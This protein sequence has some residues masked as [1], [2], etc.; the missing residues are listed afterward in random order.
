MRL[1]LTPRPGQLPLPFIL[2][3][4]S[5]CLPRPQPHPPFAPNSCPTF[6]PITSNPR[7]WPSFPDPAAPCRP[8]LHP[9]P[10]RRPLGPSPGV[11]EGPIPCGWTGSPWKGRSQGAAGLRL[12]GKRPL[13]AESMW[14]FRGSGFHGQESPR[15]S[16]QLGMKS[17]LVR[18]EWGWED[19]KPSPP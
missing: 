16:R 3:L 8:L 9:A 13:Q 2:S 6:F 18:R 1:L 5:P 19:P 10:S 12:I 14:D 11:L 15:D 17:R 7:K 4:A